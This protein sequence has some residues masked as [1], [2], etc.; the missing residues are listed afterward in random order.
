[1][2]KVNDKGRLSV[3]GVE[4]HLIDPNR[5]NA[6]KAGRNAAKLGKTR[7]IIYSEEKENS[8]WIKGFDDYNKNIHAKRKTN[9][10]IVIVLRI[11]I[12]LSIFIYTII[13]IL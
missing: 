13:N 8:S 7:D 2:Y 12:T 4:G 9:L 6:Y 11:T 5:Y 3:G 1:M 10:P